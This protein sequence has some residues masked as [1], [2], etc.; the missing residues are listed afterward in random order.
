MKRRSGFT[1]VELLISISL[2]VIFLGIVSSSYVSIVRGQRQANITRKMYSQVRVFMDDLA[3]QMRLGT[4]DYDCYP[5]SAHID[6]CPPDIAGTISSS[7]GSYLALVNKDKTEKTV[8][9]FDVQSQQLKL[10]KFIKSSNTWTSAPG[11]ETLNNS[12]N[13]F[14]SLFT[15]ELKVKNVTFSIYPLL[16]PY[17]EENYAANHYQFQP[18]MTLFISVENA[19]SNLP[20]FNLNLQTTLSSRVYSRK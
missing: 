7:S 8:Y 16:N 6:Q 5:G 11:Y 14:R 3:S 9:F 19:N 18:K 17:S 10:K 2:F 20:P 12:S 1:L 13:G 15:D 4:I